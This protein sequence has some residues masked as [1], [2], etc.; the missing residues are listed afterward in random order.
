MPGEIEDLERGTWRLRDVDPLSCLRR[1]RAPGHDRI[2]PHRRW[3]TSAY[4]RH[5][6]HRTRLNC[7]FVMNTDQI[8]RESH[9]GQ[10]TVFLEG[11]L[12]V[13]NSF[14]VREQDNPT[15]TLRTVGVRPYVD[16]H[17]AKWEHTQFFLLESAKYL[18]LAPFP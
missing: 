7:L 13:I 1:G 11:P 9:S 8:N 16:L 15:G 3:A 10:A 2:R 6:L 4:T 18:R 14:S 17:S 12:P 5:Q